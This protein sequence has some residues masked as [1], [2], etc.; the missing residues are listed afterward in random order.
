MFNNVSITIVAIDHT[1]TI[2]NTAIV[3]DVGKLYI[4]IVV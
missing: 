2:N 3:I 4:Y 1:T